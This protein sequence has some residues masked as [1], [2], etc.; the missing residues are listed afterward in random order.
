MTLKR[1]IY[2]GDHE[3]FRA[4]VRAWLE[5]SVIP[6]SEKYIEAKALP[7]EF[8]LEA[9]EN[10]FLGLAIPE[11][12]GGSGADDFRFNAVLAE[13]LARVSAALPTCVASTPTSRRR[14][15]SSW[16]PRSRSSAGS[17]ASPPVRS[18]S[19]SA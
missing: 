16:A 12:Y 9:G 17:R 10:G 14:T 6:N 13:E 19:P 1:D 18:C 15:S 8:W 3:D 4:S 2:D 11:E 7:R 5:R